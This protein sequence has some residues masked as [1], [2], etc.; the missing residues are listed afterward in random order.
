MEIKKEM[1]TKNAIPSIKFREIKR[2][3]VDRERERL[4]VKMRL[5]FVAF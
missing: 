4:S 3:K 5:F 2:K 1:K